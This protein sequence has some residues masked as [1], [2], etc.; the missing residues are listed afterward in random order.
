MTNVEHKEHSFYISRY[1][2]GREATVFDDLIDLKFRNDNPT[3]VM[4]QTV[5]APG[6]ITVRIYG[7][8]RYDVTST[9]GS[10]HQPDRAED[11]DDPGRRAVHAQQ[12]RAGIHGHRHPNAEGH[13]HRP[14]AHR[15]PHRAVQPVTDHRMR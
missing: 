6:S 11:R 13:Q 3:A 9:T 15:D 14:G 10:A 1:P 8:K 5:W 12:G 2:A 4:I 7:T